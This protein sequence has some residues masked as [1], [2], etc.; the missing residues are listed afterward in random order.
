V[1]VSSPE[2]LSRVRTGS[3]IR[4]AGVA[5][6]CLMPGVPRRAGVM[7]ASYAAA[8]PVDL[9]GLQFFVVVPDEGEEGWKKTVL[10]IA[11]SGAS[12]TALMLVATSAV[13]R[14]VLPVP[15]AAVLLGGAVAVS[16]SLLR[17]FGERMRARA[18]EAAAARDAAAQGVGEAAPASPVDG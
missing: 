10:P 15:V 3:W 8:W 14:T 5:L 1:N 17:D 11:S 6:G 13:R 18:V 7:A 9:P 12:W 4:G 2:L 16:D